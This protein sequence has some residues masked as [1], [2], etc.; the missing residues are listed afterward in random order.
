MGKDIY[1]ISGDYHFNTNMTGFSGISRALSVKRNNVRNHARNGI[2]GTGQPTDQLYFEGGIDNVNNPG[3]RS[4][5]Y[6]SVSFLDASYW[7]P[8]LGK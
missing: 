2:T 7:N 1:R 3:N 8:V 4:R 5:L 6:K